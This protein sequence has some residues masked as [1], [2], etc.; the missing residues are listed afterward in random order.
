MATGRPRQA[1]KSASPKPLVPGLTDLF[2]EVPVSHNDIYAWLL[3]VAEI[4]PQST[5]AEAYARTYNVVGKIIRAKF[6]SSF[7]E[8]LE[9]AENDPR[10]NELVA[11]PPFAHAEMNQLGLKQPERPAHLGPMPLMGPHRSKEIVKY[12]RDLV[13]RRKALRKQIGS[14]MLCRLPTAMP[15]FALILEDIGNPTAEHLAYVFQV[16][17]QTARRWIR[18]NQAPQSIMLSL[19]WITRWGMS[20]AHADAHNDAVRLAGL[21][22]ASQEHVE[23]LQ[24]TVEQIER[25]ADFGSAN[26]PLPNVSSKLSGN[27]P[28]QIST[29]DLLAQIAM[30]GR[31]TERIDVTEMPPASLPML[32]AAA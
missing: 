20:V 23:T 28:Q 27:T 22:R 9:R 19:F 5:R 12:E 18:E 25:L 6:D 24:R 3:V 2:G 31:P 26:D 10:Y 14:N 30:A 1:K 8:I 21:A 11:C 4:D 32:R 13:R 29:V 15:E 16:H 17:A 7:N